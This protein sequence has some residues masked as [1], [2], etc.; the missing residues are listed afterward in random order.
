MKSMHHGDTAAAQSW[1]VFAFCH[2][3]R[4]LK[5]DRD[6]CVCVCYFLVSKKMIV[7]SKTTKMKGLLCSAS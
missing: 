3:Y 2:G 6:L 7:Y 1:P 5:K 4:G